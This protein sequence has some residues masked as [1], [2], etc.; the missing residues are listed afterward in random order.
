[1]SLKCTCGSSLWGKYFDTWH[2]IYIFCACFSEPA[3]H[4]CCTLASCYTGMLCMRT[5]P[6][7]WHSVPTWWQIMLCLRNVPMKFD[8]YHTP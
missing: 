7:C 5:V 3:V 6:S 4:A 1:M 2:P 8:T